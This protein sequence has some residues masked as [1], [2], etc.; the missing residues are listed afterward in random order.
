MMYIRSLLASIDGLYAVKNFSKN[1]AH[2]VTSLPHREL[3]HQ[4][5][6]ISWGGGLG[7]G[8]G[9]PG[10]RTPGGVPP[11]GTPPGGGWGLRNAFFGVTLAGIWNDGKS[12]EQAPDAIF[13]HFR[14]LKL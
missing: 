4:W 14:S 11:G 9:G 5:E 13:G 10:I 6:T 2:A 1:R 7:S 3:R 8:D 12:G